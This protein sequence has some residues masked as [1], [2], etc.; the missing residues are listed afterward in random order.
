MLKYFVIFLALTTGALAQWPVN[1]SVT[2]KP[3]PYSSTIIVP[4]AAVPQVNVPQ[5][6]IPQT[7]T[8]E[9]RSA[10]S[11]PPPFVRAPAVPINSPFKLNSAIP[12]PTTGDIA[13]HNVQVTAPPLPI[14][15]PVVTVNLP[16]TP[17][18]EA[19]TGMPSINHAIMFYLPEA[20]DILQKL[21]VFPRDNPWNTDV[22]HWPTHWNSRSIIA[23]IGLDK[24]LRY[25]ADMAF[26]LVPPNQ[27]KIVVQ[28]DVGDE[29]DP[30][31][32]PVP[33]N[34]PIEGW[35]VAYRSSATLSNL[36]L[37]EVQRDTAGLGG[38]RHC[39]IVDPFNSKL[40]EFFSMKRTATGWHASQASI[41]DLKSNDLRPDGWTSADAA[42]L[43][44][45]PAVVRFDELQRGQITHA[46]RVTV[47]RT[48][49]AYVAPATHYASRLV[50]EDLPRMGERLRLRRDFDV[51]GFSPAAQTILTALKTYGMFVADNGADWFISI[52]PDPR[53]PAL[54][55]ELSRVHGYDFEVVNAP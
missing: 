17:H 18:K 55:E 45:F 3:L 4:Q 41:F 12:V 26:I 6:T 2:N 42:G 38:D 20:D 7:T 22:S 21:Q 30:G 29:S 8:I 31:P 54:G 47:R 27:P 24:Q 33:V 51:R 1:P 49:R 28:I 13:R 14:K 34:A 23:S 46:L 36:T 39:L 35:P 50:D 10:T 11:P 52:A 25:N 44:I 9:I 37:S 16:A 53:I 48:R 40:Y 43:P 32:Y 19:D 5:T 15:T